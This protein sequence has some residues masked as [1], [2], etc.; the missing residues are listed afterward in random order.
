[1]NDCRSK[2]FFGI[3]DYEDALVCAANA[4]GPYLDLKEVKDSVYATKFRPRETTRTVRG[5]I[6]SSSFGGADGTSA[7]ST[8]SAGVTGGDGWM[9]THAGEAAGLA[10]TSVASWNESDSDSEVVVPWM[11]SEEFRELISRQHWTVQDQIFRAAQHMMRKPVGHGVVKPVFERP[12]DIV[13]PYLQADPI[14]DDEYV[15]AIEAHLAEQPFTLSREE[16]KRRLEEKER[17]DLVFLSAGST[18]HAWPGDDE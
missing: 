9:S 7:T 18:P 6:H 13:I 2:T 4:Y 15:D 11:E 1:M 12:R 3:D 17:A 16:A 10:S 5:R 14:E 8:M